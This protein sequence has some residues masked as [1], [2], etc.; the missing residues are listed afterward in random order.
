MKESV[1]VGTMATYKSTRKKNFPCL[2]C[3]I[4]VKI[5]EKAVKCSLCDLWVHKSCEEMSDETFRV[6]DIQNEET[7]QCYWNCKSCQSYARKF[8]KR[9]KNLE[10]RV[11]DIENEKIPGIEEDV[12]TMKSDI[13]NL[14]ETT[15]NLSAASKVSEGET[16]AS[17]TAAVLEEMKE[18]ESRRNNLI[19]HNLSEP[20]AEFVDSK[21]RVAKDI[22]KV[23]GL[24]DQI[25]VHLNV[26]E[27]S[28][29][30]KRLGAR[31]E[32][33]TSPRPLLIGFK[34]VEHTKSVLDK[35]PDLAEKDEPWSNINII[36]DLTKT[37]RKEER[38]LREEAEK[39]N[40]ELSDEDRE[41]WKWMVVGRRGERK[42]V[43][44]ELDKEGEGAET[45]RTRSARGRGR[46][47]GKYRPQRKK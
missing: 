36:R 33:A 8:D 25:E 21:E 14:Q 28:R 20:G 19:I 42:I 6:L 47:R 11:Q 37:Q 16:H 38:G 34:S 29:F 22:E 2:R 39:K 30:V 23:Q 26:S 5:T 24:L 10:K 12:K 13:I 35:S 43:K 7:G 31:Q 45:S 1:I 27:V 40:S 46:G 32:D 17:V 9:M 3:N 18:R 44:V 15:S 41:N 4:H